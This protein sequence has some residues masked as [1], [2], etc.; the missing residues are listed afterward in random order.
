MLPFQN[1]VDRLRRYEPVCYTICLTLLRDEQ[2]SAMAA[3]Q[4]LLQL[5]DDSNFWKLEEN[6]RDRYVLRAAGPI[7]CEQLKNTRYMKTS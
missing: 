6:K 4:L 1:Q 5:F 3:Q 7:C 2:T